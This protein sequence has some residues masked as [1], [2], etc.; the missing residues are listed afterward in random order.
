M[1]GKSGIYDVKVRNQ[2]G[3]TVALFRGKS[4]RVGGE[5]VP[6]PE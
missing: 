2:H 3:S 5:I 4:L 1:T 6:Q